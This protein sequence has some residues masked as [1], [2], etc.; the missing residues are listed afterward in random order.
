MVR[1]AMNPPCLECHALSAAIHA[2]TQ[3]APPSVTNA[4]GRAIQPNSPRYAAAFS[5]VAPLPGQRPA[6]L[7]RGDRQQAPSIRHVRTVRLGVMAHAPSGAI[8]G[9]TF[10]HHA[11]LAANACRVTPIDPA[12]SRIVRVPVTR[13]RNARNVFV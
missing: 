8:A 3:P 2:A 12:A 10:Q 7:A 11:T 9:L 1:S 4:S 5:H 6:V 13:L